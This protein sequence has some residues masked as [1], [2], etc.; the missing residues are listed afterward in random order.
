MFGTSTSELKR[1]MDLIGEEKEYPMY[2]YSQNTAMSIDESW[3]SVYHDIQRQVM[4]EVTKP[5]IISLFMN[6]IK[7]ILNIKG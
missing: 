2:P 5:N 3:V 4:K 7:R 1:I 6:W